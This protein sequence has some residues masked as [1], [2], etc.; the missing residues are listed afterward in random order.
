METIPKHLASNS[1]NLEA[2]LK[3]AFGFDSFRPFQHRI[4]Q[5][6][7]D[8][9]NVLLVMPTGAG[10]SLCYQLPG[11][12]RGGTTLVVSPLIALMEDQVI[13]LREMGF[14]AERIHSGRTRELSRQVCIQYLQGRLDYL[15]I[16]PERLSVPGFPEMLA[17]RKP[18]LVA[19]DEAHCISQWGHDFRPDYRLLGERLPLLKP[20]NVIA[21]TATATPRVQ[22]DIVEQLA[23]FEPQYH[24]HGFR[25]TN[26]A[27]EM[28]ELL[29][30]ERLDAAVSFLRDRRRR[31]AIIYAPTRK[32]AES[33]AQIMGDEFG[34][35]VYHAGLTPKKRDEV[36]AAFI[37][38]D[39][40]V[41]VATI[42]FGMGIDKPNIRTVIHMAMPGSLEN[43]YQ[44]IGRAGRDGKPSR[45]I[46]YHSYGDRHVHLFF[47]EKNYPDEK[48][49]KNI[50]LRLTE[51]KTPKKKLCAETGMQEEAFDIA[52]EKLW[53]HG[54]AIVDPDESIRKGHNK[55]RQTY[56]KQKLHRLAQIDEMARFAESSVC[57]M[58]YLVN[59]FGDREDNGEPCGLCDFCA[60]DKTIATLNHSPGQHEQSIIAELLDILV[61][62]GSMG[63]GRLFTDSCQGRSVTRRE[64]GYI[65]NSLASIGLV[66]VSDDSF[67]KDDKIIHYKRVQVTGQGRCFEHSGINAI[68]IKGFIP[69]AGSSR[70]AV[71]KQR[72][73]SAAVIVKRRAGPQKSD[74]PVN[75][76]AR[77]RASLAEWRLKEAQRRK[78][79][80]F[81]IFSDKTLDQLASD[82]PT[83]PESLLE[84]KG[85]G[86]FLSNQY[87]DKILEIISATDKE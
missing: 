24:I 35:Q 31:P 15:F 60:P 4:C 38:E 59:H 14:A 39:I 81:R 75:P 63:S 83:D 11:V 46:L 66:Q 52:L 41:I 22:D 33:F 19:V 47:H 58:L 62:K 69:G 30:G 16:A 49:L 8:G 45:A 86:P 37:A 10:K 26:I 25:R 3:D 76:D 73:E 40:E 2:L 6:V 44:E 29:P 28:V 80:A 42:A 78:I 57:R 70:T 55:W 56:K 74:H 48:I 50:Y 9:K 12:A 87:G 64:F 82:R 53:I 77:V 61:K 84:V 65:L 20:A 85:V 7:V 34:A 13:K 71:K 18:V 21:M 67:E 68:K 27:I 23:L 43:Y 36:Q 5:S 54:G 1:G 17:K 79:P 72:I 51:G 32:K